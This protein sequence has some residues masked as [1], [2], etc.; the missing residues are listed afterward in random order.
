MS[1][2]V[3]AAL[4]AADEAERDA[5]ARRTVQVDESDEEIFAPPAKT[6]HEKEHEDTKQNY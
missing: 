5:I 1:E 6:M 3:Q 4:R 2:S